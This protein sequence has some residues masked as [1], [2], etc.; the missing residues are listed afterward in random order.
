MAS[1]DV[2]CAH[3]SEKWMKQCIPWFGKYNLES[4]MDPITL[5][6]VYTLTLACFESSWFRALWVDPLKR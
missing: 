6:G 5:D 1:G 4:K 3:D 2:G